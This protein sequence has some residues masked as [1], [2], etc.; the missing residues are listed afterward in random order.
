VRLAIS[1]A[2]GVAAA[3]LVLVVAAGRYAPAVGWDVASITLLIWTWLTIWPMGAEDTATYATREDPTR[4]VSDTLLLAAAVV[5]LAAVGFFLVQA[6]SAKGSTRDTL[7]A[8][9]VATVVLSWLVVHTVFTLRYAMLYYTGPDGGVD[10]N[11]STAPKYSDFAYLAFTIGMTFQV[12]DTDLQRP[13]IRATA[14]RHALLSYLF[15]AVILA[16]TINL[17]AGLA[18]SKGG[19]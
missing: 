10:F 18:S 3:V 12:S 14:L 16:T 13:A 8:L 15:G 4:P 1:V 2:V 5:S 7:A 17:V 6:S 11:Q 19:G 9:G